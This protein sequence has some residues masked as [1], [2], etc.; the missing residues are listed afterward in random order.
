M[1]WR[2]KDK[3]MILQ[4]LAGHERRLADALHSSNIE[5]DAT[6]WRAGLFFR[7]MDARDTDYRGP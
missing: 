7:Q 5:A 2:N 1:E 6:W 3:P 4:Y